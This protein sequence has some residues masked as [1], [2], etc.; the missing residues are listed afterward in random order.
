MENIKFSETVL[1]LLKNNHAFAYVDEYKAKKVGSSGCISRIHPK[2]INIPNLKVAVMN[3]VKMAK[4]A[5][6]EVDKWKEKH[7]HIDEST[8]AVPFFTMFVQTKRWGQPPKC[9]KATMIVIQCAA[10]D[11]AYPKTL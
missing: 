6:K 2:L 1:N 11:T 8:N 7:N 3:R 5:E 4:C 10:K 9:T